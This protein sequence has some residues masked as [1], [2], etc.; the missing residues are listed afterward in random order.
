[1]P[2]ESNRLQSTK[3]GGWRWGDKGK[4]YYGPNAKTLAARQGV[5]IFKA[6]NETEENDTI[7]FQFQD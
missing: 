6:Q 7:V 2:E 5:A 1:M 4:V 3:D